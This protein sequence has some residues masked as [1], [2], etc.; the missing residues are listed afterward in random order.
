MAPVRA[1]GFA[2]PTPGAHLEHDPG[3]PRA[4][5]LG[6]RTYWAL[7]TG[8]NPDPFWDRKRWGGWGGLARELE[9]RG[10]ECVFLGTARDSRPWMSGP[11]RLDLAGRTTVKQA[12]GVIA[13]ARG[14]VGIDCGLAHVAAALGVP[15]VVMFGATSEI[16][17]RPLG[18]RV[19]VMTRDVD[20]RPCQMTPEWDACT[21]W[22]C[23]AFPPEEVAAAAASIARRPLE[24][25]GGMP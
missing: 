2:G 22:R 7:G 3:A 6:G 8:C 4:F 15:T 20:C 1:L 9:D 25:T 21:S 19:R 16:K 5:G 12:A 17:N 11:G 14:F 10:E 24:N 23:M 18:P 13:G